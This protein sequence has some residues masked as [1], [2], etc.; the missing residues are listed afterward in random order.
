MSILLSIKP[1]FA[2]AILEGTKRF[3]F[4]RKGFANQPDRVAIYSTSPEQQIIGW[5]DVERVIEA[6]P[7]DIWDECGH[8]GEISY[9]EFMAYYDGCVSGIAIEVRETHELRDPISPAD[10]PE[11]VVAP[12]SFRFLADES[13]DE[14]SSRL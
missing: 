1:R 11:H 4:R 14:I 9:D 8:A 2:R 10:L 7:Q 3:E 6:S 13:W 12:Q 5:F